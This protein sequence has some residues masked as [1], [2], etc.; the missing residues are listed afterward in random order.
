MRRMRNGTAAAGGDV[1]LL[2]AR[3]VI[4]AFLI[5]GVWDNVTSAARMAEFAG[6]LGAPGF[7]MPK[8]MAPL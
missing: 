1:A 3:V 6:F 7:P 8:V 4:G 5:W 2:A